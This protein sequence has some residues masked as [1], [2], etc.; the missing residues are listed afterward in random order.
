M[1]VSEGR[2]DLDFEKN[3]ANVLPVLSDISNNLKSVKFCNDK[4]L[5]NLSKFSFTC[6]NL[7]HKKFH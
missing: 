4:K 5:T 7:E 2:V 6:V 3:A 1:K